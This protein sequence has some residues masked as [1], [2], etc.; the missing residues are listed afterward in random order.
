MQEEVFKARLAA[1]KREEDMVKT[2]AARLEAEKLAYIRE[3]KRVRDE[4]ASR[5]ST[6]P[7]LNN[8]YLLQNLL[9]RGG[10][11]EVFQVGAAGL[12][13][14]RWGSCVRLRAFLARKKK[15]FNLGT[16]AWTSK[17]AAVRAVL[18]RRRLTS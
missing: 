10:F 2:E 7:V 9:G 15:V 14:S 3:L 4:E 13:A 1:L 5:F 17:P 12:W 18:P 8:R 11:S 6:F 16:S